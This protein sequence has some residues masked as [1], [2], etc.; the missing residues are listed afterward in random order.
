M[1]TAALQENMFFAQNIVRCVCNKPI[2]FKS[3]HTNESVDKIVATSRKRK[4]P[5]KSA[6]IFSFSDGIK[7][8]NSTTSCKVSKW[9]MFPCTHVWAFSE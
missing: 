3:L 5:Q 8:N 2:R 4:D 9:Y 7:N 6:S 1:L